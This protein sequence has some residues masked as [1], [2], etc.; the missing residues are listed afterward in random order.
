MNQEQLHHALRHLPEAQLI[1]WFDGRRMRYALFRKDTFIADLVRNI[2]GR[3]LDLHT[4]LNNLDALENPR[5]L[6][7]GT[8]REFRDVAEPDWQIGDEGIAIVTDIK[9]THKLTKEGVGTLVATAP[10]RPHVFVVWVLPVSTTGTEMPVW[11]D[12]LNFPV[13]P[14]SKVFLFGWDES[15]KNDLTLP[16]G[17]SG[18]Y[19]AQLFDREAT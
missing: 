16:D 4:F 14:D 12:R 1:P 8:Q 19:K 2:K 18:R 9:R 13:V 6:F 3:L 5:A 7:K 11:K 10:S 15:G 17:S